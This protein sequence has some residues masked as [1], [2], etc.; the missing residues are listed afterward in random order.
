MSLPAALP[1]PQVCGLAG[2]QTCLTGETKP[3]GGQFKR[4]RSTSAE[5][6]P[7]VEAA[8]CKGEVLRPQA[9]APDPRSSINLKIEKEDPT[10]RN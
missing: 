1:S 9:Q 10:N 3:R 2:S 6:A 5:R 7:G 4:R 8:A